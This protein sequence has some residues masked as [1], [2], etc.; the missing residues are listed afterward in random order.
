MNTVVAKAS[1]D[2]V[3]RAA[4]LLSLGELVAFP[5]ETVYGL[6]CDAFNDQAAQK[7]FEVK[8]R[9]ADNPL[10]VHV[11]DWPML[12]EV[13]EAPLPTWAIQLARRFWP[14]P[15]TLVMP[16]R[17]SLSPRVRGGLNTVAVRMPSH[18]VARDL[19]RALGRPIAAPSANRSGR[20]SPTDARAVDED[21]RGRIPL[22]LDGGPSEVGLE[23]TVV[24][25]TLSPPALLRPGGIGREAL[26]TVVGP[27]APPT[28]GGLSRSPGTRYRHYAPKARVVV[29][30]G[31][32]DALQS[33]LSVLDQGP[34]TLAV[35][36]KGSV[37]AKLAKE[38]SRCFSLGET[39]EDAAK[40]LFRG[41][42]ELDRIDPDSIAV[43]WDTDQGIGEAILNRLRKAE[44]KP[45]DTLL[46]LCSG[47]TCRSPMAEALW[48][49]RYAL[50]PA[51]SAGLLASSGAPAAESAK[52]AVA[53]F[54]ASL[55]N[56]RARPLARVTDEPLMVVT[57]TAD[58][59]QA[60]RRLRPEWTS[61]IASLSEWLH[62]DFG[63]IIDPYGSSDEVYQAVARKLDS[64]LPR[65]WQVVWDRM[66]KER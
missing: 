27:L 4:R 56:H 10:I 57:M 23:S 11:L 3:E 16:S 28:Q 59:A 42:R 7:I 33:Q 36:A 63:D 41:L 2:Q 18:P 15:L 20:P 34:G 13:A 49:Q 40:T 5:T 6:G 30:T 65:L 21:L 8:G 46:F 47:N 48:N 9:P 1:A 19:L 12:L 25:I 53:R 37:L 31:D 26:E 64:L 55:E 39:A 32:G 22:I 44:T 50:V 17:A 24:D 52:R 62:E 43:I 58:Q 35:M 14:G 45:E 66:S 38:P 29:L 60:A 61:R 54:G 51:S